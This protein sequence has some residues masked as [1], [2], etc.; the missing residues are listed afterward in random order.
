[1]KLNFI[2]GGKYAREGLRARPN[3]YPG[4]VWKGLVRVVSA[5]ALAGS[6]LVSAQGCRSAHGEPSDEAID[7]TQPPTQEPPTP[8]ELEAASYWAF[9]DATFEALARYRVAARVLARERYWTGW[10]SDLAP[11][12]LALGWG[13]LSDPAIDE[14][15]DW[16]QGMR[17]YFWKWS[18]TST[19]SNGDISRQSAN[20]HIVPATHNL[21]RALL[22]VD[23]GDV[24]QLRGYLVTIKG[25][26]GERWKSSLSRNDTA[27][28][29]CELLY[30]TELIT[31][32]TV[33]R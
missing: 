19:L 33:Y 28:G 14:Y 6:F 27:G 10:S 9:D 13:E 11:V 7:P 2:Y 15:V 24:I 23:E 4:E 12:D 16:Y 3:R 25:A 8:E 17:W 29:S 26:K 18:K 31:D 21:K 5:V 20:T 32:E 30:A 1:M 22:A